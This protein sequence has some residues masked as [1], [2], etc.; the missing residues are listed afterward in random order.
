[1]A[2]T[3]TMHMNH[4]QQP[5]LNSS[6]SSSSSKP[7]ASH[8]SN[9]FSNETTTTTTSIHE[10]SPHRAINMNS[11][12]DH[13]S[14]NDNNN[15]SELLFITDRQ[16][17]RNTR[18]N[19]TN[20]NNSNHYNNHATTT[21]TNTTCLS[22]PI[23][24][25]QALHENNATHSPSLSYA[26]PKSSRW[27]KLKQAFKR[28]HQQANMNAPTTTKQ[29]TTTPHTSSHS[30][31]VLKH[32]NNNL[33]AS[34]AIITDRSSS[35]PSFSSYK[36]PVF[37]PSASSSSSPY[38]SKPSSASH[39]SDDSQHQISSDD[40]TMMT[41]ETF[42]S[43]NTLSASPKSTGQSSYHTSPSSPVM[44]QNPYQTR[45]TSP[46]SS[47]LKVSN[48][49][50]F[51]DDERNC[52]TSPSG[53]SV[54]SMHSEPPPAATLVLQTQSSPSLT[55]NRKKK[56]TASPFSPPT[57][58]MNEEVDPLPTS[59]KTKGNIKRLIA[60]LTPRRR[61][62]SKHESSK[63]DNG[64]S[65]LSNVDNINDPALLDVA[66]KRQLFEQRTAELGS[67]T[68]NSDEH[69][70]LLQKERIVTAQIQHF[71]QSQDHIELQPIQK[72]KYSVSGKLATWLR[73][74]RDSSDK[75]KSQ[76]FT[77]EKK[78]KRK[79]L[80]EIMKNNFS[81]SSSSNTSDGSD[82]ANTL[83]KI[84]RL[85]VSNINTNTKS[86]TGSS[87]T[88]KSSDI[89]SD[90]NLTDVPITNELPKSSLPRSN[91]PLLALESEEFRKTTEQ[92]ALELDEIGDELLS[93][94]SDIEEP[95]KPT[96]S[97]NDSASPP[98]LNVAL[99]EN[100]PKSVLSPIFDIDQDDYNTMSPI[101]LP[102][103]TNE[104]ESV[105]RCPLSI[106]S[107]FSLLK[108]NQVYYYLLD[109][110]VNNSEFDDHTC[111]EKIE[112]FFNAYIEYHRTVE[113]PQSDDG[114]TPATFTEADIRN[115]RDK[116]RPKCYLMHQAAKKNRSS[117]IYLLA[118][119]YNCDVEAQDELESSPLHWA[120]SHRSIDSILVL[121]QLKARVNIRDKY[122]KA[123]LHLLL[124][125]AI[126]DEASCNLES[127]HQCFKGAQILCNMFDG[128]YNFKTSDGSTILHIACEL[129]RMETVKFLVGES[130]D[131]M[132]GTATQGSN[133][134]LLN[135]K[136][137]IGKT[138]LMRAATKGHL[139]IVEYI[140]I[141][142]KPSV[143]FGPM[144]R[145]DKKQN[146]LHQAALQG[147]DALV[148]RIAFHN[149]NACANMMQEQDISGNSPLHLAV[150]KGNVKTVNLFLTLLNKDV[151]NV[152]NEK[153]ETPLHLACKVKDKKAAEKICR[154]LLQNGANPDLKD[155]KQQTPRQLALENELQLEFTGPKNKKK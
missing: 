136:D 5:H 91:I 115:L 145:D 131:I 67:K 7:L 155:N 69:L 114:L 83:V 154:Y 2:T 60:M 37:I 78:E 70:K 9:L 47:L 59:K 103:T 119:K 95:A 130:N 87:Q 42:L 77:D 20:S 51:Q 104:S 112:E 64:K 88:V 62:S 143:V 96:P 10:L 84:H 105:R 99:P 45:M 39:S 79:S 132:Q 12:N 148:N 71:N 123:P 128:D 86:N 153:C 54:S 151:V 92:I 72:R 52:V 100:I 139:D 16:Q 30:H 31:T 44:N 134:V 120:C 13:C 41:F 152:I 74:G 118:T 122:G 76:S 125:K 8:H 111:A 109:N 48:A 144:S 85:A 68:V 58:E 26:A 65:K 57:N 142:S 146:I 32:N 25:D 61:R 21:T 98:S 140:I 133:R 150:S 80:S 53:F 135:S 102:S 73:A 108:P 141:N 89:T 116:E 40:P 33:T 4:Q 38:L 90:E 75:P 107:D 36:N 126:A 19:S 149:P 3:S 28:E 15:N 17:Y 27:T 24:H 113:N 137:K 29:T 66:H 34:S 94:E 124:T 147:L 93:R 49:Y 23:S 18:S 101:R 50:L 22:S 11:N 46:T 121:C 106:V 56:Q 82:K 14:S 1:M 110:F 97:Q 6:S 127:A 81:L 35:D 138:P 117:L 43:V 55:N 129:G 63:V